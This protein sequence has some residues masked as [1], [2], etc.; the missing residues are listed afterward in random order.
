MDQIELFNPLLK[1]ISNRYLKLYCEVEI[2][3]MTEEYWIK[4]IT[5]DNIETIELSAIKSLISKSNWSQVGI[6]GTL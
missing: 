6:L 5:I 2:I 4:G 3:Y 1:I